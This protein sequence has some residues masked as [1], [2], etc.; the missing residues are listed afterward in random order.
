MAKGIIGKSSVELTF[1]TGVLRKLLEDKGGD[2]G[3]YLDAK[4]ALV[5]SAAKRNASGRPGPNVITGR[6]RSSITHVLGA[7]GAGLYCDVGAG[8]FYMGI[9]EKRGRYVWL[10]PAL[11]AVR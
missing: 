1:N 10:R 7:D 4:G 5:E 11:S 2:V 8:A 3:R 9:L 6:G